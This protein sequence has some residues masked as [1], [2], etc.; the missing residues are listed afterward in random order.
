MWK[1]MKNWVAAAILTIVSIAN[2]GQAVMSSDGTAMA[3][4]PD[5]WQVTREAQG[6]LE[7]AGP[8]GCGSLGAGT[9]F[10]TPE[11]AQQMG[12]QIPNAP[13]MTP[14]QVVGY[15]LPQL[16]AQGGIRMESVQIAWEAD[17]SNPPIAAR[18]M[19]VNLTRNGV[20]MTF[21]ARVASYAVTDAS[22]GFTL[23][24]MGV[25][26]Q[27]FDREART[28]VATMTSFRGMETA[29]GGAMPSGRGM[30]AGGGMTP[31]GEIPVGGGVQRSQAAMDGA[32]A[33]DAYIRGDG[34]D[35]GGAN[36]ADGGA[37]DGGN[38]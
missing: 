4:L 28:L 9:T 24:T 10:W 23:T 36:P 19:V 17:L 15:L 26:S 18:V 20:P 21:L 22:W 25:R 5:G 11:Y 6:Y 14:E 33:F 34:S 29:R 13:Y 38:Q 2:A 32:D 16:S 35:D 8:N 7:V 31:D 27:D 37:T 1:S 3:T 12:L 30:A